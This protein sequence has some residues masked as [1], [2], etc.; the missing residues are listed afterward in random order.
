MRELEDIIFS[1][2]HFATDEHG[3]RFVERIENAT[4]GEYVVLV[5]REYE[6]EDGYMRLFAQTHFVSK[7]TD[8][9]IA[10]AIPLVESFS[11]HSPSLQAEAWSLRDELKSEIEALKAYALRHGRRAEFDCRL[12][13]DDTSWDRF[14][15]WVQLDFLFV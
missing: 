15:R 9:Y 5:S 1:A 4:P 3:V 2:G 10:M 7:D 11:D 8:G 14:R 12:P 13:L 6:D